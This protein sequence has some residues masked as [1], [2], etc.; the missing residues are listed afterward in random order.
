MTTTCTDPRPDASAAPA[1]EHQS[2]ATTPGIDWSPT[3]SAVATT[4]HATQRF[5]VIAI[6][7]TRTTPAAQAPAPTSSGHDQERCACIGISLD[8]WSRACRS[9]EVTRPAPAAGRKRCEFE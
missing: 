1:P 5:A 9:A 3:P 7:D 2:G 6:T 8:D 4:A